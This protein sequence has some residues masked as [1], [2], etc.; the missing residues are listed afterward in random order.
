M[1]VTVCPPGSESDVTDGQLDDTS[2]L[3][4]FVSVDPENAWIQDGSGQ[5]LL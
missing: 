4:Q 5:S 1:R 2:P 3:L